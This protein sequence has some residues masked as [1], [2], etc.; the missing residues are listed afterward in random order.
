RLGPPGA[1]VYSPPSR[2]ARREENA[3]GTSR[4]RQQEASMNRRTVIAAAL[5]LSLA[6][7]PL[8]AQGPGR[9]PGQRMGGA[10]RSGPG[11]GAPMPVFPG[12]IH[13]DLTDAQR[14]QI[15]TILDEERAAGDPGQKLRQAEQAL[16][17]AVLADATNPQ[18]VEDE[19]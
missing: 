5:A 3:G 4:N 9:G 8:S 12:L 17:A 11:P 6:A 14:E 19:L 10:G 7:L 18:D 1:G 15:R 2:H 13:L 16:H